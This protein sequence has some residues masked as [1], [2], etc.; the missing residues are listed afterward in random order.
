[1][2][3]EKTLNSREKVFIRWISLAEC[4][5]LFFMYFIFFF[6]Y[7]YIF[8][9]LN[10]LYYARNWKEQYE[11][12]EAKK[13]LK[14]RTN[15]S[16]NRRIVFIR[17]SIISLTIFYK[18]LFHFFFLL[19]WFFSLFI[20]V[21]FVFS[22]NRGNWNRNRNINKNKFKRTELKPKQTL[23][24]FHIC[25]YVCVCVRVFVSVYMYMYICLCVRSIVVLC[26]TVAL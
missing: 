18:V 1:M 24:H 2:K 8:S 11:N 17:V 3:A 22:F 19:C 6:F 16:H 25:M 21:F 4:T 23:H 20:S 15:E 7:L 10:I 26:R 13:E 5:E 14:T 9:F 12:N